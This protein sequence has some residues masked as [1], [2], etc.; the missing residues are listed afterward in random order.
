MYM[1]VCM[2]IYIYIYIYTRDWLVETV[3]HCRRTQDNREHI[4]RTTKSVVPH[5]DR[6]VGDRAE[7]SDSRPNHPVMTFKRRWDGPKPPRANLNC[8]ARTVDYMWDG[9]EPLKPGLSKLLMLGICRMAHSHYSL[10]CRSYTCRSG[11]EHMSCSGEE[12]HA[13][14]LRASVTRQAKAVVHM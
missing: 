8:P 5:C 2:C 7:S 3:V 14:S 11:E 9:P 4:D 12:H 6:G 13:K 1:N 10:A